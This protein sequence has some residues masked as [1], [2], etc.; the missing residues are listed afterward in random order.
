MWSCELGESVTA[1]FDVTKIALL[2]LLGALFVCIVTAPAAA[3]WRINPEVRVTGGDE[4]DLVIDPGV[5]RTVVPGGAFFELTPAIAART[6]V[7]RSGLIDIGTFATIQNFFNSDSR[8]LYGQSVWGNY[9]QNFA[10]GLRVRASASFNYFDDSERDWVRRLGLGGE[11][12]VGFVR[13]KWNTE[14]WGG[15][16][17]RRY[18]NLEIVESQNRT[19]AYEEVGWSGGL[20]VRTQPIARVGVRLDGIFQGTEANDAYSNSTSWTAGGSVD[21]R[22]V[23]TLFLTVSGTYQERTFVNRPDG[24]DR[25]DYWQAG[26]GIRYALISGWTV[27]VRYGYSDYTWTDGSDQETHR[28]A[29]G[30]QYAWGRPKAA[31]LPPVDLDALARESG[32]AVQKPAADN[33]VVFRIRAPRAKEVLV[34]GSFNGWSTAALTPAGDGWWEAR[35]VIE[36]GTY[37][38]IYVVDGVGT[39]PPEAKL[40][41]DDGFGGQNGILDVLPPEL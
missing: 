35:L 26:A 34:S 8:L 18:P 37:E 9:L 1:R 29:I 16:R 5:T 28:F 12:G 11:L 20:I 31:P 39:P 36:P 22:L 41:V 17:G 30:F 32:G 6:F 10:R 15:V 23:S 21:A 27:M 24:D 13:R 40:T 4:S 3:Q 7:G 19:S 33:R 25:D 14:L 2:F 38:Y